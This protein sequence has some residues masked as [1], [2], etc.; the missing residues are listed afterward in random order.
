MNITQFE[1][2][3]MHEHDALMNGFSFFD[4][5][6][7]F[8]NENPEHHKGKTKE[9]I[10]N[11]C[12]NELIKVRKR[13][14]TEVFELYKDWFFRDEPIVVKEIK[15]LKGWQDS[16]IERFEEYFTVGCK[17]G[18]DVVKEMLE[19]LP[20]RTNQYGLVQMG[21]PYSCKIDP[22][23]GVHRTTYMTFYQNNKQWYYAGNCFAGEIINRD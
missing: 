16:K 5:E 15:T 22:L 20:P 17:V 3:N 8:E 1:K 9:Q 11:Y 6:L 23:L 18:E 14:A 7:A 13:E 12:F 19:V 10:L 2:D 21:E 4:L